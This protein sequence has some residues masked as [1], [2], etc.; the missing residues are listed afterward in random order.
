MIPLIEH[1]VVSKK[2]WVD[3]DE[4]TEMLA[5]AQSAPGPISINTAVFVGHKLKGWKGSVIAVL[6]AV[7]PS[8]VT[9]L[10]IALFFSDIIKNNPTIERI[11]KGIRPVVVALIAAPAYGMLV[12]IGFKVKPLII[13]LVAILLIWLLKV[14]PVIVIIMAGLLG[15]ANGLYKEKV[16]RQ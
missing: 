13:V 8:F 16:N 11:F 12:K 1:E 7:L 9:I 15:V 6:G 3:C 4:F 10:L 14:S 2:K 5:L